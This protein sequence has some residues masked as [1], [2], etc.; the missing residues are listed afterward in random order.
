MSNESDNNNEMLTGNQTGKETSGWDPSNGQHE[1]YMPN[2]EWKP[3][4]GGHFGPT[5]Y[6][7]TWDNG[8]KGG[9]GDSGRTRLSRGSIRLI[10]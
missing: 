10:G 1:N 9:G 4:V 8:I 6:P 2:Y 7:G 5:E 3:G